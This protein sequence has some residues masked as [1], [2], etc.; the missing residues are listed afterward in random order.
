MKGCVPYFNYL[1]SVFAK[2][3]QIK[4]FSDYWT[5]D[6]RDTYPISLNFIIVAGNGRDIYNSMTDRPVRG[7]CDLIPY[8]G[9][10]SFRD[11]ERCFCKYNQNKATIFYH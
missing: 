4:R 6:F 11:V 7:C 5:F 3:R 1:Y 9:G 10:D 8:Y 2:N